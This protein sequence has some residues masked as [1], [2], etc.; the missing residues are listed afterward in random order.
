M[1]AGRPVR[2]TLIVISVV[3]TSA[4][5]VAINLATDWK[6]NPWAW[7]AVV[8]VTMLAAVVAL[9]LDRRNLTPSA[10]L[11]RTANLLAD[12]VHRQWN[13]EAARRQ[14]YNPPMSVQWVP[15]EPDLVENWPS[16]VRFAEA[17]PGRQASSQ[18]WAAGPAEL[19]GSNK[20]LVDVLDKV[21]TKRLVVLGEPGSGKTSLLVR[22]VLDLLER[23]R[24]G[25]RVPVLLSLA[26]WSPADQDLRSWIVQSLI[27]EQSALAGPASDDATRS[28]AEA[29]LDSRKIFPILDGFDELPSESRGFALSQINDAMWPEDPL[30]LAARTNEYRTAVCRPTGMR[31]PLRGA[32]GIALC[33]LD[34]NTIATYLEDSGGGVTAVGHWDD[35]LAVLTV[36]HE[37][38]VAKALETPLMVA[39][40]Q[41]IYNPLP[42]DSLQAIRP[43]AELLDFSSS[44]DIKQHLFDAFVPEAAYRW[45]ADPKRRC[46]WTTD[47]V[48]RW[49]VFLARDLEYRQR[50]TNFAW[51]NLSGAAPRPLAGI[52]VG[53]IAGLVGAIASPFAIDF[54]AGL[55]SALVIGLIVYKFYRCDREGL[56][57]GLVG[58]VLGG[59]IGALCA[60][61]AFGTGVENVFVGAFITG[62]LAFGLAVAPLARFVCG[63]AG[64]FVGE[65]VAA[66]IIHEA[67]SVFGPTARLVNGLGLGFVAGL[68][69]WLRARNAPA[70]ELHL[71]LVGTLCGL[72]FGLMTGFA[73]WIQVGSTT[74][75]LIGLSCMIAAGFGGAL[76][77]TTPS[78]LTKAV[79]PKGVLVRDR[80]TFRWA[81]LGMGLSLGFGGALVMTFSLH[82][83][84]ATPNGLQFGLGVG[85]TNLIVVGLVFAFFQ[86]SWG[87]FA[88]ARWW[89]AATRRLPW[90]LMTFL[91]DA[92]KR[93][94]LRQ[95]GAYYQFRHVELQ[96]HL[97]SDRGSS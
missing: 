85:L 48:K 79:N 82:F 21:P 22:L 83:N 74:S 10:N 36:D 25:G 53:V 55:I 30:V 17:A 1:V 6:T 94:V 77:K 68:A 62:G 96:R 65:L 44:E 2:R 51:W 95:A 64:G 8:V 75:I 67:G 35:V 80:T 69:V 32:A 38:P 59:L 4:A 90:R 91:E 19:T 5:A 58:G 33:P 39:L 56:I 57:R 26:S 16:L 29:L 61:A 63:L 84:N 12:A 81:W 11:T 41:S 60:I 37:S 15:S 66:V 31:V 72:G 18:T 78:E 47:Q 92:H 89:L 70:R 97:A 86:A 71:S 73:L 87:S 34:S 40:A 28:T 14:L 43:P 27:V 50:D 23:R 42:T 88:L 52:T 45:H 24:S 7:L 93:D 54:G 46:K 20:D 3:L 13:V 9:W 49:L 76:F